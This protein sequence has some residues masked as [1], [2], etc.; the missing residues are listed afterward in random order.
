[1]SATRVKG[2]M[3]NLKIG[4]KLIRGLETTGLKIKPNFEE[5]QL[6]EYAGAAVE[7]LVDFDTD[8]SFSGKTYEK[9]GVEAWEDFETLREAA[10]AGAEVD[11]VY[12]RFTA[13]EKIVTGSGVFS[14]FSEEG[15]SKDTG[16]FSGSIKATK[17]TVD[18]DIYV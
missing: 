6:K 12:G 14:D 15:N 16:T 7:E 4:T 1:M 10:F 2:F 11:F 13:G 5:V 18:F 9:D 3:L 8:F 17:G